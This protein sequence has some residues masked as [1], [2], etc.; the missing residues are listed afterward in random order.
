MGITVTNQTLSS[1]EFCFKSITQPSEEPLVHTEFIV[2]L[3][4]EQMI[5]S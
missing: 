5:D 4:T 3:L 2:Q 1:F